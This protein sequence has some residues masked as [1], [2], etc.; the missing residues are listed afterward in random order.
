M[1]YITVSKAA[2]IIGIREETLWK[3]IGDGKF[4]AYRISTRNYRIN[5]DDIKN[6]MTRPA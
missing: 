5:T 3:W 4:P 2:G 1:E 6:Y